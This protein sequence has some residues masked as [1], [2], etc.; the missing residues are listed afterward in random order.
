MSRKILQKLIILTLLVTS[1]F[2][3][4]GLSS[5]FSKQSDDGSGKIKSPKCLSKTS[6]TVDIL[7]SI[8][9][10]GNGDS[11]GLTWDGANL[12]FAEDDSKMMFK[13][14]TASGVVLDSFPTPGLSY[15]EGLAWDGKYIWHAEY[16]G[17]VYKIDPVN[18]VYLDTI[19]AP[20]DKPTGLTWDG[21]YLWTANY[22]VDSIYQFSHLDGSLIKRF[23]SPGSNAWGLAKAKNI[24]NCNYNS[25]DIFEID[26]ADG[27]VLSSYAAPANT[28]FLGLT[29][30]G[31]HLWAVDNEDDYIKKLDIAVATSIDDD[32]SN[33][34]VLKYELV[35]N[36][37]NPFN[38]KTTILY[39][40]ATSCHVELNVYNVIGQKIHTLVNSK[41][42]AGNHVVQF[43]AMDLPSGLYYY[44]ITADRFNMVRKMILIK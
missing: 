12:W 1:L 4:E 23:T 34:I 42:L 24:W 3:S 38:P 32:F 15:T 9:A 11:R 27:S 2:I 14:D 29:F 21:I 39:R 16:N 26:P 22:S 5:K 25:G 44:S 6:L 7:K 37:P 35:Q 10:P 33:N 20:T 30:D 8:K 13:I 43:N 41:Q 28:W 31:T 17:N 18:G 40:L 36:Y 19:S